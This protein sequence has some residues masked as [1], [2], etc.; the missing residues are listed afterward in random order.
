MAN[1]T[2][3]A[4]VSAQ[5]GFA[6][7]RNTALYL[8]L[9]NYEEKFKDNNY[10]ICLEHYD[11]FLF[12]FLNKEN[13]AELIEAYQ[14]KKKSPTTWKLNSDLYEIITKLLH[15]GKSL[16]E[17]D[18]SKSKS[19]KHI[20]IFTTNQTI[21]LKITEKGSSCTIKED[22]PAIKF[23]SLSQEIKDKIKRKISDSSLE[24][25]LSNLSFIWVDLNRTVSKQEN[26]LV[27]QLDKV[28][29]KKISDHRAAINTLISLFRNI[30]EIY[31]KGNVAKLLDKTKRV[32][33]QQ[34][35]EAFNILTT[36]S[37]CF[38]YWREQINNITQILE[39]RPFERDTFELHFNTA[40]DLFKSI[41]EAEHRKI[42]DFVRLHYQ[43]CKT[44]SEADNISELI[45]MFKKQETTHFDD[46]GLKAI[47][48]AAYFEV[49]NNHL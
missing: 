2:V 45:N 38:D 47:F 30:E 15:T 1:R 10:F 4:G 18:F 44:F 33:S 39:I 28:F 36:K 3:N 16:T 19:Y 21:E 49:T 37:K 31:N 41:D 43:E 29:G 22:N 7:Q 46:M 12:C 11:D 14:S 42:L 20:L 25:E 17:D 13:E 23:D 8:L 5:T 40:F 34:I 48:F 24:A 6:L 27:G 9:E 35:E 26:E 32:T